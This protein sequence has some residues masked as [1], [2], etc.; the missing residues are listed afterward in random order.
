LKKYI[1]IGCIILAL[2][3]LVIYSYVNKGKQD[4]NMMGG[5]RRGPGAGGV[6]SVVG[7]ATVENAKI[8]QKV[9]ISGTIGARTEVEIYPKQA[10]EIE[11][12]LADIGDHVK[13]GQVLAKIDPESF[14]LQARQAQADLAG[15]KAV[16]DKSSSTAYVDFE[17]NFKQ[18]ENNLEKVSSTLKQ[19]ELD[20]QLQTKQA[21]SNIKK[22]E[23]DLRVAQASLEA[24]ES[25]ARKQELEQAR[26]RAENAKKNLDRLVSLAKDEM[27]SQDQVDAAQLQYDI[28]ESQYSL[29]KEGI[30]PE[31]ME[32]LR[33][34]FE[35]AKTALESAKD[36]KILIDIKKASLDAAKAQLNDANA[37]FEKATVAKD[38]STWQKELAQLDAMVKKAEAALD[39][40][41]RRLDEA[42]VKAPISGTI[43]QRSLDKGD[44]ASTNSPFFKIVD[45][46]IVKVIAKVSER[47]VNSIRIGQRAIIK[48]DAYPGAEF[49]GTLKKISPVIDKDSRT[50]DIEIEA[51]NPNQKLKPGMFARVELTVSESRIA[52]VVPDEALQKEENKVFVFMVVD[53]KAVRKDVSAGI[54]D[55]IKTEI[56]SGLQAGDEVIISGLENLYDGAAVSV[57]GKGGDKPVVPEQGKAES[58]EAGK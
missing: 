50:C 7:L 47:D 35:A 22:A 12:V 46:D 6:R 52:P 26:I 34:K 2:I 30:R 48:P 28:Y 1:V 15:A 32:A 14:N 37:L 24:A 18:A 10:G 23:A 49:T 53:D 5:S 13:A 43:A 38:A 33:A 39:I 4:N 42:T 29:L 9:L 57:S 19:A 55:G 31:D 3:G 11:S 27:V 20:L 40:A 44:F 36:N 16:Y 45:M 41:K 25:G 58:K 56:I 8:A 21:D 17:T 51:Q 54:S